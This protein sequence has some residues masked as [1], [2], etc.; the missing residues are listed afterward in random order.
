MTTKRTDLIPCGERCFSKVPLTLA[1][2][3]KLYRIVYCPYLFWR[4]DPLV[5]NKEG[6]CY[7]LGQGDWGDTG[8]MFWDCQKACNENT[9]DSDA[10]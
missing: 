9:E 4:S 7:F 10:E 8:T 5:H 1:N 3:M 2:E 6:Y